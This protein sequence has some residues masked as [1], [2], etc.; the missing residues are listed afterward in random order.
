MGWERLDVHLENLIPGLALVAVYDVFWDP[1]FFAAPNV[2]SL[3]AFTGGAYLL[4]VVTNVAAR[5]L[6]DKVS[7]FT[8]RKIMFKVFT[9]H[10]LPGVARMNREQITAAYN[11]AV[12]D[13]IHCGVERI[14]SEVAKRRQTC[15]LLRTTL[16]PLGLVLV[17][18]RDTLGGLGLAVAGLVTY[19]L[20]LLLNGY[21]EVTIFDEAYHA[22]IAKPSNKQD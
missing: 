10:K 19:G 22:A 5:L 18:F 7:E 11:A 6:L 13:A 17:G 2:F 14:S 21:A 20:I 15:R 1:S 16:F 4:G 12:N 3:T 8:S 9:R